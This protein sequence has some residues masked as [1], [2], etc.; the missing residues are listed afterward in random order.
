[1][2][3]KED[4]EFIENLPSASQFTQ[5]LQ[6]IQQQL[7]SILADFQKAYIL[8]NNTPAS[9]EY[10]QNYQN[11]KTNL[12]N[13]NSQLF[14]LSNDVQSNLDQIN[15]KLFALDVLI[16]QEREKNKELKRK[17]GIV[18]HKKNAAS[19]MILNYKEIYKS[20]Y[21]R[22]WALFLSILFVIGLISKIYGNKVSKIATSKLPVS[23]LPPQK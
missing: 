7:P 2:N 10:E 15:S 11:N 16:K 18:E 14:T 12:N 23:N 21:L 1:M 13:I 5:R 17:L 9:Q 4:E 8:H 3:L 6:T 22:N 19:E 20:K